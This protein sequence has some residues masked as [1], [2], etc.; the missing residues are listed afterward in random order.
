MPNKYF[1]ILINTQHERHF[2]TFLTE[3][4]KTNASIVHYLSLFI[5]LIKLIYVHIY[6]PLLDYK[7]ISEQC[8]YGIHFVS[9]YF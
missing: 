1:A 2:L 3:K 6:L 8:P 7:I 5:Y 9:F 4:E